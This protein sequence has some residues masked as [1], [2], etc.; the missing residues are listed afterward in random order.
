[1]KKFLAMLLAVGF[2]LT[3]GSGVSFAQE[4][5]LVAYFSWSDGEDAAGNVKKG[6]TRIIA[7]II[8]QKT[9]GDLFKIKPVKNY[10][11]D[12][13]ECKKVASR[14]KAEK[15]RPEFIGEVENFSD[16]DTIFIGYPIWYGDAPMIVYTFL[17]K[18][19]FDG[20]KIVPFC[21]HGGSGLSS[22]DQQIS[23]T[24]PNS[25][26]LKGFEIHGTVAQK[27]FDEAEKKVSDWLES[28][29]N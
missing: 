19:N 3:A 2:I 11:A 5:I 13:D 6:N 28:I 7:D 10:P 9:G 4:K 1:M 8:A 23:L 21:T 22:T 18:Y 17:E 26:I 25:E 27:N 20:K 24:C 14:E 29:R 15:A 12:Y 16:Y